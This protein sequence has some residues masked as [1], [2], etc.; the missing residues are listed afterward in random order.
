M[1]LTKQDLLSS[2]A[3]ST[4]DRLYTVFEYTGLIATVQ[5]GALQEKQRPSSVNSFSSFPLEVILQG[6]T[7][8]ILRGSGKLRPGD[9]VYNLQS[10]P[11]SPKGLYIAF[12]PSPTDTAVAG[13]LLN[14]LDTA[15]RAY[16]TK[17]GLCE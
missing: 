13:I 7:S 14:Q 15:G 1:R 5:E 8:G 2:L 10:T 12:R 9:L 3:C 11:Q 4:D 16:W 6:S 17:M